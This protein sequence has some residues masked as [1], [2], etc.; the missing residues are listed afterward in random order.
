MLQQ[1]NN[2]TALG[3]SQGP[4]EPQGGGNLETLMA[5]QSDN[6]DRR[7]HESKVTLDSLS[8][9]LSYNSADIKLQD[10]QRKIEMSQAFR[11]LS[12]AT[13]DDERL[14][15]IR[16]VYQISQKYSKKI[17]QMQTKNLLLK[18]KTAKITVGLQPVPEGNSS[19]LP[20]SSN[21]PSSPGSPGGHNGSGGPSGSGSP[22]GPSASGS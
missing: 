13:D 9:D 10:M 4:P 21:S 8:S 2:S 16:K 14:D 17:T 18:E 15:A 3:G 12:N 1:S 20:G 6:D 22:D 11:E 5:Y 7:L 19:T